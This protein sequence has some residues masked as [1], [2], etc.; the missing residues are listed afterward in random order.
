MA[1]QHTATDAHIYWEGALISINTGSNL[2]AWHYHTFTSY[3]ATDHRYNIDGGANIGTSTANEPSGTYSEFYIGSYSTTNGRMDGLLDELRVS[4]VARSPEWIETQYNN[5]NNQVTFWST[6]GS[7]EDALINVSIIERTPPDN[8]VGV[9]IDTNIVMTFNTEVDI[10]T[11]NLVVYDAAD[12]SV[13]ETIDLTSGIVTGNGTATVTINPSV[14]LLYEKDYYIEIDSGAF[15]DDITGTVSFA[16]ITDHTVW[17]FSTPV[18]LTG[19]NYRIEIS[20]NGDLVNGNLT[21]YPAYFDLN[22]FDGTD[23]FDDVKSDGSD[24]RVTSADGITELPYELVSLDTSGNGGELHFKA[25]GTN[26]VALG[27]DTDFYIYYGNGDATA[28]GESDTY[29]AQNVWTND[30]IAV[31][32]MDDDPD[33]SN[34]LDSSSNNNDGTFE[35]MSGEDPVSGKVGNTLDFDGSAERI[36]VGAMTALDGEDSFSISFWLKPDVIPFTGWEGVFTR[37]SFNQRTPWVF[38]VSSDSVIRSVFETSDSVNDANVTMATSFTAGTWYHSYFTFAS[39]LYTAYQDGVFEVSDTTVA[40][41]VATADT[42]TYIAYADTLAYLDGQLDEMRISSSG[43]SA[44][45]VLTEYKTPH[46]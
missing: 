5:Q 18:W 17:N 12:D 36:D 8:G 31:W 25:S 4:S 15:V 30:Y 23:F 37:G 41:S 44:G 42:T 29:G 7:I 24:I 14:D 39:N 13:H 26:G 33:S 40:S 46:Y 16:G 10:Q 43:R 38:A 32:H 22:L 35:N 28:Y 21:D 9:D 3:S 20:T 34:L 2:N 19:F 1:P 11:G 45:W 27:V 6:I